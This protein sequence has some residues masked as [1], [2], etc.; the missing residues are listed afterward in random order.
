MTA[1][2]IFNGDA[3]GICSLVQL[4]RAEPREAILVT[5]VKRDIAL[6]G[7]VNTKT[8]DAVTV[9]DISMHT[10]ADGLARI[11]ESGAQVFYADHHY[12]SEIQKHENLQAVIDTRPDICTALIINKCL[13][14]AYAEWAVMA[15]FGDNMAPSAERTAKPLGLNAH[16][17]TTLKEFGQL[18]N[19]N[20]YGREVSDLHFTPDKLFK[21]LSPYDNP[22]ECI[23]ASPD[24]FAT[25][26]NGYADDLRRAR[27]SEFLHDSKNAGV[28]LLNDTPWA[29]RIS[30]NFSNLL[31][32][33]NP[34][35]PHA[36]LT[37][38]AN[39]GY[40]I[41]V[42]APTSEPT[43]A[44]RLCLQFPSGGGRA[45]AAGI[46]DLPKNKLN[47]FLDALKTN[48]KS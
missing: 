11:L 17:L 38:N 34:E 31:A 42:R 30:G 15:A 19:Y 10:N 47:A 24:V 48:W 20:G 39:G 22:F 23:A 41:S 21:F 44:D 1:F 36:I 27:M 4:R 28:V 40:L 12:V 45:A 46:N 25:L 32:Q 2:D 7:R 9:L 3:D 6:L 18:V 43:G 37:A 8:G 13:E 33:E 26:K 16:E 29:R 35:R 5:G 14:G